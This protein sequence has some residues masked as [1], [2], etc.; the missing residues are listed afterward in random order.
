MSESHQVSP[1]ALREARERTIREL[2]THF[3]EDRL[4]VTDLENRLDRAHRATALA[5]LDA[6]VADLPR[7]PVQQAAQTPAPVR[8]AELTTHE[9]ERGLIFSLMA[10]I[11]RHGYW[12]PARRNAVFCCM[13]GVVLDF[14]E[15]TLPPGATDINIFC[16][17]GGIEIIVPPDLVVDVNGI[18]IIGEIKGGARAAPPGP[19]VPVLR[20]NG[21]VIMGAVEISVRL[22]G[23]SKRDARRRIREERQRN[24]LPPSSA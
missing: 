2:C 17:M 4:D 19:D 23:E 9:R 3:A 18:P 11:T 15:I 7:I 6:L 14:R 24:R 5:D 13:G 1:V 8:P 10:N 12:E 22:P 16:L 21:L 20:I